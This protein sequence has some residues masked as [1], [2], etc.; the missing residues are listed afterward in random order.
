MEHVVVPVLIL[1]I[2]KL[3]KKLC[4]LGA[5]NFIVPTPPPPFGLSASNPK[6]HSPIVDHPVWRAMRLIHP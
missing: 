5:P 4:R 3:K 6:L 2:M 1:E